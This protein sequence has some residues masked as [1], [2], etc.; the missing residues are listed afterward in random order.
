MKELRTK[1]TDEQKREEKRRERGGVKSRE[2][3]RIEK[4]EKR[5]F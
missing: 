4:R 1:F 2:G 5:G 3:E